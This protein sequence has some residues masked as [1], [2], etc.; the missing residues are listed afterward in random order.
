MPR[1]LLP[2]ILAAV[3]GLGAVALTQMY[4]KQ[5]TQDAEQIAAQSQKDMVPTVFAAK[6]IPK[7][8]VIT[9][10]MVK[11]VTVNKAMLQPRAAGSVDRVT[12][13][14][15]L[16][17]IEKDE[18]ILTNKIALSDQQVSFSSK[19][20][21]GKRAITIPVDNI[22]SVGG[23]IRPGD[24]VDIIGAVPIPVKAPDGQV[25]TQTTTL[26]LFQDVLILAVGQEYTSNPQPASASGEKKPE[27]VLS[28]VITLALGPQEANIIAF[29]QEQARIRLIL[30]SPQDTQVQPAAPATW[31]TVLATLFPQSQKT[32]AAK[33]KKTVEIYRGSQKE[34]RNIE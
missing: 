31:D 7:D 16:A 29:V 34:I 26:P 4:I 5:R 21:P 22:S 6:N 18:Q 23:M 9:E 27:K 2:L 11:Q 25:T 12:G 8:A 13:R 28:P 20:P 3:F 24:H 32:E 10:D 1:K 33:P 14:I 19:V 30:R 17:P 15:A